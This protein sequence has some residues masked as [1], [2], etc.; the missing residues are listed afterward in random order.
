MVLHRPAPV[1]EHP[2][3][4]GDLPIPEPGEGQIR[5]HVEACGVCHTD[6]HT[7]E[8]DLDLPQLP[9]VPGHQIVG[10]VDAVGADVTRLR[11]GDRI[12]VPWVHWTCGSCW[13][14]ESDREN[15]CEQILFTGFHV[16]G[17]YAEYT[18][19]PADFAYPLPVNLPSLQAAPLLCAGIIGYRALRVS[20]IQPGQRLGLWGFGASAHVTIQMARHWGCEVFVVSRSP[21]HLDHAK[22]LGAAWV[23]RSG[24]KPPEPLDAAI[25]FTP[26][27]PT[28]PEG[29][30]A[31][32]PGGTLALAGIHMSPLPSMKYEILYGERVLRSVANS[33]RSDAEELLALA[34]ELPIRT[35]IEVFPLAEANLALERMARS[36]VHGAAVL[37]I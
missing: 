6:L 4:M 31:L 32:R 9:V 29:L 30:E 3:Q 10:T 22:A 19:A 35:D 1:G 17:G 13:A 18:L 23:G 26:A 36:E 11:I 16:N 25:N 24:E 37:E 34:A 5:I 33:T 15:L 12:G 8:G 27:G 28:V 14:C 21:D 7:V 2:L 20:G